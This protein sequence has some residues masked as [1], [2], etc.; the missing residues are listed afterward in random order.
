MNTYTKIK[1]CGL[2]RPE[3]IEIANQ[4]H[5]DYIGFVFAKK[6]KRYIPP[7]AAGKLKKMLNK[8]NKFNSPDIILKNEN[9]DFDRSKD[10]EPGFCSGEN[11]K[12]IQAVGV[13]VDEDVQKA[14]ELLNNDI[15]DLAQLHGNEDEEYIRVLRTLSGKPIIKAFKIKTKDDLDIAEKSGADHIF[16]DAGA[17]DGVSFNWEILKGFDR[18]YFLAGGLDPSNIQQA[19]AD[20]NPYGVD[21]SS[22]IETDGFKDPE[23]MHEFVAKVRYTNK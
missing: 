7:E 21:V 12:M 1:L 15:I 17:G 5:P 22:G 10:Y 20:L 18:P 3:D 19:I 8:G 2:K 16:L 11:N 13:F 23:K 4:L 9:R 6:S 14:A